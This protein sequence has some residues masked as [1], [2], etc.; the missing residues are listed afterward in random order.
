ML[1]KMGNSS[2][3]VN[4]YNEDFVP[5]SRAIR[6]NCLLMASLS[7]AIFTAVGAVLGKQWLAHYDHES[8]LLAPAEQGRERHRKF[9]GLQTW[10]VA[11][12][13]GT[14]PT[15]LQISLFLFLIS[16]VDLF[17][18]I[19]RKVASI[20]LSFTVLTFIFYL[21]TAL[22]AVFAFGSPFQTHFSAFLYRLKA[23]VTDYHK[24]QDPNDV[25]GAGCV[26]WLLETTSLPN[27]AVQSFKAVAKLSGPARDQLN[28]STF[29][30]VAMLMKPVA[31]GNKVQ[32][33][34][35]TDTLL[36]A[37]PDLIGLVNASD[38]FSWEAILS[39]AHQARTTLKTT[40]RHM[41]RQRSTDSET[42]THQGSSK[43]KRS[44]YDAAVQMYSSATNEVQPPADTNPM[45]E[46]RHTASTEN[47]GNAEQ[48]RWIA[49]FAG[50]LKLDT[51]FNTKELDP[52]YSFLFRPLSLSSP[53]YQVIADL[54]TLCHL[55]N[56][57][58]SC[59]L[60]AVIL[61][62]DVGTLEKHMADLS[63]DGFFTVLPKHNEGIQ[64]HHPALL[65]FVKAE[66]ERLNIDITKD[67]EASRPRMA[68]SYLDFLNS[69]L[70]Q[71]NIQSNSTRRLRLP[72]LPTQQRSLL[73]PSLQAAC[74]EWTSCL[75]ES[76]DDTNPSSAIPLSSL[77]TFLESHLLRWIEVLV[78][79]D[80]LQMVVPSLTH[81]Q[82]W[83]TVSRFQFF[84]KLALILFELGCSTRF[85][86]YSTLHRSANHGETFLQSHQRKRVKHLPFRAAIHAILLPPENIPPSHISYFPHC[87]SP[88]CRRPFMEFISSTASWPLI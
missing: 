56:S 27:A 16:L 77:E 84:W 82:N 66:T 7:F 43:L 54:L 42:R 29:K 12:V 61:K 38:D 15:L 63:L 11:T 69:T 41:F 17:W 72:D 40:L 53:P 44:L 46:A 83:L 49:K 87:K 8:Q 88:T 18:P 22:V 86:L 52:L 48:L 21:G 45:M 19:N 4:Y 9:M 75:L 28:L 33:G 26:N 80:C 85:Y 51:K 37:L 62:V 39:S 65:S 24:E 3:P 36:S 20:V 81:T 58:A 78:L 10:H 50:A 32:L 59:A 5:S 60:A 30:V 57:P 73:V 34:I 35:S 14:L 6:V 1:G 23:Y 55:P 68:K 64:V 76:Y 25:V 47:T 71:S 13:I 31:I 70:E 67:V 74:K 2:L 79:C